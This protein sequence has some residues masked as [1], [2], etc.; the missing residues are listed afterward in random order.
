MTII[1]TFVA[2][3]SC[4]SPATALVAV[5]PTAS[6]SSSRRTT[7]TTRL[8]AGSN[9]VEVITVSST[10]AEATS[11]LMEASVREWLDDEWIEQECHSIIAA[12]AGQSY[13]NAVERGQRELGDVLVSLGTD[14]S[15]VAL[16]D[17]FFEAYVGPWDVAN[18]CSDLIA[19]G[20]TGEACCGQEDLL[21]KGSTLRQQAEDASS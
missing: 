8:G 13:F 17:A 16:K 21:Q 5:V 2:L 3:T 19:T 10:T 12:A 6:S 4:F 9:N 11:K 20:A 7:T 14:L 18:Y 1:T 15:A